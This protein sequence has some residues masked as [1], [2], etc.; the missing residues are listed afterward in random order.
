MAFVFKGKHNY[1][2]VILVAL[3]GKDKRKNKMDWRGW[4]RKV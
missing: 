4:M 2:L 3:K 1:R